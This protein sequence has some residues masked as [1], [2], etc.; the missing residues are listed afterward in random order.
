MHASRRTWQQR[1]L[2]RIGAAIIATGIAFGF[3]EIAARMIFPPP[4]IGTRQPQ[5][6]YLYD[7]EI[8]YVLRPNQKSWI[9]DGLITVNSQGFRGP[10][11]PSRKPEGSFRIVVIGDSLTLGWGVADNETFSARLEQLLRDHFPGQDLDVLNLGVGGYNTRQEVTFLTRKLRI[12]RP[13]VVLL[14]FYAN[15]VPDALEDEGGSGTRIVPRNRRPGEVMYINPTPS[16]WWHTQ[17][18]KSRAIFVVGRAV[19]RLRG[20]GD[21]GRAEFNLELDLLAGKTS[22]QLE[23]AWG[24]VSMELQRLRSLAIA[25]G[26]RV[27]VVVLPCREQVTGEN[28][29]RSYQ[30]RVRAIGAPLGFHVID[31][32]P[33]MTASQARKVDLFIPYDRNHPSAEGHALIAQAIVR[34]LDQ[35]GIVAS[36]AKPSRAT[37]RQ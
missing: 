10:E 26:F 20:A 33:M 31:P 5:V 1:L 12:L 37:T 7:P 17:L 4:P 21:W 36:T 29:N 2:P 8:R 11:A 9:D 16:G 24:R 30:S 6:A 13:D 18:R 34:D 27:A 32:L 19:N 23:R 22:P 25:N 3:C 35:N 14:G 15:D 28:P